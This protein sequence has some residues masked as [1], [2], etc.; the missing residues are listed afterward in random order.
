M[1]R[2]PQ[3]KSEV[4]YSYQ[5]MLDGL[6][7]GTLKEFSPSQSRSHDWVREIMTNGGEIKEIVPGVPTYT[8]ALTK[9]RLYTSTLLSHFDISSEN[10][11][12]QV[13]SFDIIE[14]IWQ[15]GSIPNSSVYGDGYSRNADSEGSTSGIHTLT[16]EDCWVTEWGKNV[17]SDGILVMENMSVQCTR[18]V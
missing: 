16:Y 17:S 3:T 13:R 4:F 10:I 9:V 15:P 5:I 12:R 7:I 18:V 8:I 2:L 1:A 14:T 11:Q 6:R